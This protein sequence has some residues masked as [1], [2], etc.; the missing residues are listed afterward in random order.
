MTAFSQPFS[1]LALICHDRSAKLYY[2]PI[3]ILSAAAVL[4]LNSKAI[5]NCKSDDV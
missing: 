2:R 4:G 3:P 1:E 5:I